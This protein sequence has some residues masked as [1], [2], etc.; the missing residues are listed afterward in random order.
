MI[1]S[2]KITIITPAFNEESNL[3]PLYERIRA[4]MRCLEV[5]WDWLIVDDNS[6]DNTQVV[7]RELAKLDDRV[8]GIR[9]SRNFGSHHAIMCGFENTNADYY[10]VMAADLQDPPEEIATLLQIT[11]ENRPT[12]SGPCAKR[13][14]ES[15]SFRFFY[16]MH[17]II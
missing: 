7:I 8:R 2:A 15:A 14:K 17:I 4:S 5:D 16:P 13:E 3:I 1:E 11:R 10:V 6:S 9:L 12:W